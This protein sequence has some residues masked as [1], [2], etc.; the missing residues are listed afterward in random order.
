MLVAHRT[1]ILRSGLQ[2]LGDQADV[3]DGKPRMPASSGEGG[4]SALP[5]VGV[6]LVE[7]FQDNHAAPSSGRCDSRNGGSRAS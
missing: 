2:A 1:S 5:F 6:H 4:C 3:S 7:D